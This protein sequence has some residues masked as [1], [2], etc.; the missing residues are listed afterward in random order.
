MLNGVWSV[1]YTHLDV[2]KRQYLNSKNILFA[3]YTP[4]SKTRKKKIRV[5]QL[6]HTNYHRKY[7]C[8]NKPPIRNPTQIF[9]N[10]NTY[11]THGKYQ[12]NSNYNNNNC[13]YN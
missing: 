4:S 6:T 10:Y 5:K 12:A 7:N 9:D 13:N 11:Y 8:S 3:G 2:Y 1:S